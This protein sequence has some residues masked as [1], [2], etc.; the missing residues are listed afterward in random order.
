MFCG[1][2]VPQQ[3]ILDC[4]CH[5]L[6]T[7]VSFTHD[8]LYSMYLVLRTMAGGNDIF[9]EFIARLRSVT[10]SPT[11]VYACLCHRGGWVLTQPTYTKKY[12]IDHDSYCHAGYV[13]CV[14]GYKNSLYAVDILLTLDQ[15]IEN[16]YD[17]NDVKVRCPEL[18]TYFPNHT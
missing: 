2:E 10:I 6:L 13:G 7:S 8:E 4:M 11:H 14:N 16:S 17:S 9:G 5:T 12:C 15:L 3:H 18:A 1:K